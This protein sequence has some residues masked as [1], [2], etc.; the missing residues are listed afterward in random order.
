MNKTP[1]L[2][3]VVPVFNE[4]DN[5]LQLIEEISAALRDRVSFEMLFV[6]DCSRDDTHAVLWSAKAAHPELRVLKHLSQCGQSTAVRNGVVAA[7]ASWIATLDGD[8]QNNPADLPAMLA[9]R[10][11]AVVALD[12]IAGWRVDRRDTW[13]KRVSS[14]V[15]NAVRRRILR[16]DTPDSGCGIKLI[17]R[18]MFLELPYFSHMHRYLPALVQRA[19]GRT[20]SV[21][22]SHRPRGAGVSKYGTLDRL[23]VGLSDLAGVAW[24]IRRNRR[25]A[26]SEEA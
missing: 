5:V 22:V 18:S 4:R 2:S 8:G 10:D 14:K 16:D 26:V 9:A 7:R 11:Q 15:A 19:G 1:D 6:D 12:L 24:L 13:V 21:P 3:V 20:L 17:R 23:M 25:S